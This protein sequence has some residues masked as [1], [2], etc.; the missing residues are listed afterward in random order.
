MRCLFV[1]VAI[2]L[3]AAQSAAQDEKTRLETWLEQ[4]LS[5]DGASVE[6]DGLQGALSSKATLKAMTISDDGGI[7]LRLSGAQLDWSRSA[8]LRGRLEINQ[9]TAET[10]TVF[11]KPSPK[12]IT[13]ESAEA[14]PFQLPQLP[15]SVSVGELRV[16]RLD[17]HAPVLGEAAQFALSG[18]AAL[19]DGNGAA[20]LQMRRIDNRPD[21][22]NIAASFSNQTT[23]LNI[24]LSLNEAQNG[25]FSHILAIPGRPAVSAKINGSGPLA[26]FDASL[27]LGTNAQTHLRGDLSVRSV[28]S[29][30]G[31]HQLS[32]E[33][34]GDVRPMLLPPYQAFFGPKAQLSLV[35][36]YGGGA[37]IELAQFSAT[38]AGLRASASGVLLSGG[39]PQ[40]FDAKIS[41]DPSTP[42]L[43]PLS[44][45]ETWVSG[46]SATAAFDA[47]KSEQWGATLQLAGLRRD[48]FTLETASLNAEGRIGQS[49]KRMADARLTATIGGLAH[50]DAGLAAALGKGAR[51]SAALN[52]AEG[53]PVQ[54]LALNGQ[55]GAVTF[56]GAGQV[57]GGRGE[58]ALRLNIP[59]LSRFS[60]VAGQN[61]GGAV[62]VNLTGGYAPITGLAQLRASLV[63]D[64]LSVD[65]P[66]AD[67]LLAGRTT[68]TLQAERTETGTTLQILDLRN[69][70]AELQAS[71]NVSGAGGTLAFQAGLR[72]AAV[73]LAGDAGPAQASG[74]LQ[75]DAGQTFFLN[76]VRVSTPSSNLAA[77]GSLRIAAGAVEFDGEATARLGS[78]ATLSEAAGRRLAGAAEAAFQGRFRTAPFAI[79]GKFEASGTDFETGVSVADTLLNGSLDVSGD[80]AFFDNAVSIK[81]LQL[82]TPV[83]SVVAGDGIARTNR[84]AVSARLSDLGLLVPGLS[85]AVEAEGTVSVRSERLNANLAVAGPAGLQMQVD[86]AY[87]TQAGAVAATVAGQA[88]LALINPF[89]APRLASGTIQ[90]DLSL[91]GPLGL[92]A[93][94]GRASISNGRLTVSELRAA[95]E[96]INAD[97][98]LTRGD[99]ALRVSAAMSTGGRVTAD[100]QAGLGGVDLR[101]DLDG[102]ILRDPDLYQTQV[103]GQLRVAGPLSLPGV[104]ADLSLG[105]TEL[106]IPSAAGLPGREIP[107]GLVHVSPTAAVAATQRRAGLGPR[108]QTGPAIAIPLDIDITAPNR[109]FVRGRGLD[110]E[111]GGRVRIA[112]TTAQPNPQGRFDLLR[113]RFDV[114]G[115]RLN[116]T[117]GAITL[118]GG[119]DP[120]IALKAETRAEDVAVAIIL[121]GQASAPQ[122]SFTSQPELPE[123]EILARLLFGRGA[124]TLSPLQA[125][126]L[127]S[128]V[129]T[130]AGRNE[131]LVAR[132]RSSF[133]V[134]DLDVTSTEAGE[135]SVRVGKYLSENIYT[136]VTVNSDGQSEINLNLDLIPNVTLQGGAATD[137]ETSVGVFWQRDY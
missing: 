121:Q 136:D 33:M 65:N 105:P 111:L 16:D 48:G 21:S 117:E 70:Q 45:P 75:W 24:D 113:G 134:D 56:A 92:G 71:G 14:Q 31:R 125:V 132:L 25:L 8:L 35:A 129:A 46:F 40:R 118:P 96:D 27:E 133:G 19:S 4:N 88:P 10:L 28:D 58:G 106:R 98:Q 90:Y 5:T 122:L 29:T 20:Q 53:Q 95:L 11:R 135:T 17:L 22:L 60:G 104:S 86:G 36:R 131:G 89:I 101:A 66:V 47:D 3:W 68:I 78:L 83:L 23:E 112:G 84:S 13:A 67:T 72:D 39:W 38:S 124:A 109:I 54:V 119:F 76:G 12:G 43:L 116:L 55:S 107:D 51:V 128:A 63:G 61:L 30:G 41:V 87:N 18:N 15:V 127:A 103:D 1:I 50:R 108:Q 37:G 99:A 81:T 82:A 62:R 137:G 130:L 97:I 7:W 64:T 79:D 26:M 69:A 85:G 80:L 102:V 57:K 114:L 77:D 126:Q 94:G 93:L 2:C 44:G 91:D 42:V 115:K 6:I 123:E 9:I 100:G 52:W 110:A 34:S 32:A 73:V 59:E 120:Q 49:P 74:A